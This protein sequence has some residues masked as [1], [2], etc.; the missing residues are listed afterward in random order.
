MV[1]TK[2]GEQRMSEQS[3]KSEKPGK[4]EKNQKRK[5]I[6]IAIIIVLLLIAIIILLILLLKKPEEEGRGSVRVVNEETAG[7]VMDDMRDEVAKGIFQCEMSMKWFYPNGTLGE[8]DAYVAN[9]KENKYPIYFD[10]ILEDTNET[11]YS[12]PVLPVGTNVS[13]FALDKELPAGNHRATVMYTLVED[14]ES[15]KEISQ[16]GFIVNIEVQN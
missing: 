1:R 9:S 15:Q 12:S 2:E 14:V 11:V 6:I 4:D 5:K 10:V 7:T 16:A 8:S 13:G 3:E